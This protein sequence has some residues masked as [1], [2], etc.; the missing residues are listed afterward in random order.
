MTTSSN[1]IRCVAFDCFG[2]LF[3]MSNIPRQQIAAYVEHVRSADF[4]PYGFPDEWW[5]LQPFADV[6]PGF[7]LLSSQGVECWALSNGPWQ[8]ISY[9]AVAANP[10]FRFDG[11]VD[12]CGH[13]VY[14]PHI[15]A[16]RKLEV[17]SGYKPQECLMVTANPTF[18]DVEGSAAI[19][20][21][22]CVIRQPDG[23]CDVIELAEILAAEGL[24]R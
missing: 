11:I 3:D 19:G 15:D 12:L 5:R 6:Q 23:V 8:L 13:R 17:D 14:K 18:G 10:C 1:P 2:T 22:S 9:L 20:M 7:D 16:Y 21:R 24:T 4:S